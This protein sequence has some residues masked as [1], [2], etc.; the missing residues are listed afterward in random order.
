MRIVISQNSFATRLM[1]SKRVSNTVWNNLTGYNLPSLDLEPIAAFLI[2]D[3]IME[4]KKRTDLVIFYDFSISP[5]DILFTCS[6][7]DMSSFSVNIK[8]PKPSVITRHKIYPFVN[9]QLQPQCAENY[10][11]NYL[12]NTL[13]K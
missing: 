3:L 8:I 4:V 12:K 5:D 2:D 11:H 10:F 13:T 9:T 7:L 1:Q 6:D